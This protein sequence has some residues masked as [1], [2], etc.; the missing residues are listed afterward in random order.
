MNYTLCGFLLA[1]SLIFVM[2]ILLEVSRRIAVHRLA[3]DPEG[4][5][6]GFGAIEG[7]ALA[8]L[9]LL[10]A[11]N[12]SGAGARFDARRKFIVEE[13]HAIGTAYLRLDMLPS[14]GQPALR[15]NFRR[16][17]DARLDVYRKLPNLS[18]VNQALAKVTNCS[19]D[20]NKCI[21]WLS[22]TQ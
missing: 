10:P 5:R 2:L 6:V 13:I 15:E 21:S 14:G 20:I 9:G 3:Q 7:V 11:F 19:T 4:A 16:Y 1:S 12:V 18:A 17:I 8:L 22:K